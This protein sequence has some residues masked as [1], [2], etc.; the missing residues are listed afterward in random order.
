MNY[1]LIHDSIIDRAKT[2]VLPKETYTERHHIIPRCMDG[3]DDKSNL[4]DL[5]AN[6]HCVIHHLLHVLNP[7]NYKLLSAYWAMV[8]L[9]DYNGRLYFISAKEMERLRILYSQ[10]HPSKSDEHR[11]K[12]SVLFSG[13]PYD[14][15]YG[16]DKADEIRKALSE[17]GATRVGELNPFFNKKHSDETKLRWSLKRKNVPKTQEFI[18]KVRNTMLSKGDNHHMKNPEIAKKVSISSKGHKKPM[19]LGDNNPAKRPEVR[20]KLSGGN[21]PAAKKVIN[22]ITNEIFGCAKDAA[23]T[24]NMT[25]GKLRDWLNN[26]Q[27]NKT[28]FVWL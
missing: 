25:S 3:T 1:Q 24:I 6:E 15:R 27:R 11:N 2:R 14:E 8:T 23:L 17:F 9:K 5:T 4:V 22:K 20:E 7:D 10:N 13:V 16:K 26:P 28:Y 21:N 19:L 18:D 12:I